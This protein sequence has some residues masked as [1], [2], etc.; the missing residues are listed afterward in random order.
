MWQAHGNE[1]TAIQLHAPQSLGS[2]GAEPGTPLQRL[3]Q[4]ALRNQA[5]LQAMQAAVHQLTSS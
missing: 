3:A 5:T 4:W 1:N 2:P